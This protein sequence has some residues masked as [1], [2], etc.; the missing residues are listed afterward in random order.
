MEKRPFEIAIQDFVYNIDVGLGFR[1][2]RALMLI[3]LLGFVMLW[4]TA[5]RFRGLKEAE[6][7]ELAQL[8]R[9]LLQK[10]ALITQCVRPVTMQFLIEHSPSRQAQVDFHPDVRNAPIY[11]ALL[12]AAFWPAQKAFASS[13]T[14]QFGVFAP[15]QWCIVP[16]NHLF[17]LLSA[18]FV[19]L[20]ARRLFSQRIA[21]L[22]TLGFLLSRMVWED[23]L[24]GLGLPVVWCF[25]LGAWY[26]LLRASQ[27]ISE[28]GRSASW[29]LSVLVSAVLA[30]L[31]ILTRYAV[32]AMVPGLLL[33]LGISTRSRGVGRWVVSYL[34]VVVLVLSPWW[35]RNYRVSRTLWGDAPRTALHNSKLSEGDAIDRAM[36]T[37][38]TFGTVREAIMAKVVRRFADVYRFELPRQGEGLLWPLFLASF[39]FRFSRRETHWF[40]WSVALGMV[41]IALT[42]CVFDSALRVIHLF[43]PIALAYGWAFFFVLLDRL[44]L[45]W[46][47]LQIAAAVVIGASSALP[48]GLA[49]LPPAESIPYPPYFPRFISAV[50]GML[51][52]REVM[53]TDMPWATAWYGNRTSI[54]LPL[55]LDEFYTI[56]DYYKGIRGL[57]FTTLTR[58]LP[59][60]GTLL[61]GPYKT[62][63]PILTGRLPSDFPLPY[64]LPINNFRELFLSDRPRWE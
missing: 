60:A 47:A 43:W 13:D 21:Q 41:V 8:G 49:L 53:C 36:R 14:R 58:D 6:A 59:F 55:S 11:P 30:G 63:F 31:A 29:A 1:L 4:F 2:V 20:I 9:N 50:S 54:Y 45:T 57:Y 25:G 26:F 40:R 7:M 24:A 44:Q 46:R 33:Y 3:L 38:L 61:T 27:T 23:S 42:A 35:V 37:T 19:Y 5:V 56:N 52:E 10:K 12:A 39:L 17:T 16:L 62:W 18:V 32:M 51:Q 48:F 15:E 22:T 34:L 64:A 28:G